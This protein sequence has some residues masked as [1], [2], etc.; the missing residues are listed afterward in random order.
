MSEQKSKFKEGQ[1]V[2]YAG[3]Y[4]NPQRR[5]AATVI[6]VVAN[7]KDNGFLYEIKP[8]TPRHFDL[9]WEDELEAEDGAANAEK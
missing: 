9:Y 8:D 1:R 6:D 4:T 3:R 7:N 2:T 5:F